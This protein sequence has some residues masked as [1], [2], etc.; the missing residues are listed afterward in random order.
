MGGTEIRERGIEYH[1]LPSQKRFHDSPARF[2]GF[3]GPIGSGKS[4]ALCQEAIKLSYLGLSYT[5]QVAT[6]DTLEDIVAAI[7]GGMN[8]PTSPF[9]TATQ[10][11]TTIRV[12]YPSTAGA[13]G[14]R[15]GIY[16]STTGS[17]T[18]DAA[19]KT[20]ANGTSPSKWRVTIDF[21]SLVDRDEASVPT[22]KVRKLRW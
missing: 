11:G 2:K 19:A 18:W 21:S 16:S 22:N 17:A 4:Q 3:S 15:V 8:G 6:G 7:T 20:L 5:Y 13:S 9:L 1:P 12:L 14:N 10:T